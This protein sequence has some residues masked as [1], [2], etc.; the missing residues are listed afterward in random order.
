MFRPEAKDMVS[1]KFR[2]QLRQE[3]TQWQSESLIS[4]E[5]FH[6]LADRYDFDTLETSARDRFIA[7]LVSIGGILLGIGIITFVAANWQAIP[8]FLK[9]IL[10][11]SVLITVNTIGFYLW[12]SPT[13]TSEWRNRLG[14]GLLICGTLALGANLAL[15]GQIFHQSGTAFGFFLLWGIGVLAMAYGLRLPSIATIACVLLNLGY[16]LEL[17]DFPDLLPPFSVVF[18]LFPIALLAGLLPL[19]HKCESRL[20]FG[21]TVVGIGTS[22]GAS[23]VRLPNNLNDPFGITA[24]IALTLPVA[25][26]WAYGDDVG[27]RLRLRRAPMAQVTPL[28]PP[29]REHEPM[30]P[31]RNLGR[32]LSVFYLGLL[33][34]LWSFHRIWGHTGFHGSRNGASLGQIA[35][36]LLTNPNVV[37]IG[38]LTLFLW[39]RLGWFRIGQQWRLAATDCAILGMLGI[40]GTL[41]VWN[42]I[43]VISVGATVAINIL[44]FGLA[45]GLMREGLAEGDRRQ[46]WFGLVLLILQIV[47]RVFEYDT[48]LLLKSFTFLLCGVAVILIGLWFERYVRTFT[49]SSPIQP[50][51]IPS[52]RSTSDEEV[53]E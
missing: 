6:Q 35:S 28:T 43:G 11:L 10:L 3:A 33:L 32:S 14:Q 48:G 2:R 46:F 30:F 31:F 36:F 23:V 39:V 9:V 13:S 20:V 5:L 12:R 4:P 24:A 19:A 7:I 34:Y 27:Y 26:W 45:A 38:L 52:V 47:S 22:L 8:R 16:W 15:M 1:E 18:D 37:V 50:L 49:P 41:V 53:Q 42:S 17:A 40:I 51:S 29:S 21:L 25:L 44:L